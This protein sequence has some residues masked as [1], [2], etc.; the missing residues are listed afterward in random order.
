MNVKRI[1]GWTFV[2]IGLLL[3]VLIA[4]AALLLHSQRFH[5]YVLAKIEQTA[6]ES[7]GGKVTIQSF[8][9]HW[10]NLSADIY[11]L[12]IH[13]REKPG[14]Q[15]LLA[16][17]RLFVDVRIISLLHKQ[18]DL[19]EIVVDH[20]VVRYISYPDGTSN[21]P[22]STAP[23]KKSNTNVFDLGIKH[24]LLDRGEIYYQERK[25]DLDADL[26]NLLLEVKLN[27]PRNRYDGKLS[28]DHG[29]LR[30]R[31]ARP[32]PH[33]LR[34]SFTA[35]RNHADLQS[36]EMDLGTSRLW[37]NAYLENYSTPHLT[38][39]YRL[40]MYPQD[41]R[42][43]LKNP[44]L[45]AGEITLAGNIAYN[46]ADSR[47]FMRALAAQGQLSSPQ[48]LVNTP[49]ARTQI[50]AVEGRFQLNNGKLTTALNA[51]LLS[52]TF[53]ATLD[54]ANLDATPASFLK[55]SLHGISLAEA[56]AALR[57][58]G[59]RNFPVTGKLDA[60]TEAQ[61]TGPI[62]T[63][64][65]H[66]DATLKAAVSQQRG[67]GDN[68][69]PVNGAVHANYDGPSNVL[70]LFNTILRT[71]Q[72]SITFNGQVS[73]HSDLKI[74]ART[75]DVR[76]LKA[77][78]SSLPS[79]S[80]SAPAQQNNFVISGPMTLDASVRG[81][82]K[83]PNVSGNINAHDLVVQG[84]QWKSVQAAFQASPSG[85]VVPQGSLVAA[86]K[87][88]AKFSFKVG[89]RDWKYSPSQP[90]A[91]SINVQQ[92]PLRDLQHIGGVNYPVNGILSVDAKV[93]G[94]QLNPVGNG[95]VMVSNGRVQDQPL[96]VSVH[97]AAANQTINSDLQVRTPA[98]NLQGTASYR[99]QARAYQVHLRAPGVVLS[100]LEVLQ[101]RNVPLNGTLMF[102]ADGAGTLDDPQL[103]A[104]MQIP[105]LQVKNA[106]V[107]SVRGDL[108]VANHRAQFDIN[109]D[110]ANS[111]VAA[112]GTVDLRGDYPAN[113][114]FDTRAI[115]IE[116]LVALY[117]P[118][119]N[120]DFH[121]QI[122]LHATAR[123]PLKNKNRMEAH[124]IIPTLKAT[125][126]DIQIGNTQPIRADYENAVL[127][128]EPSQIQGTDTSL[129]FQGTVPL[130]ASNQPATLTLQGNVDLRIVKLFQP[131]VQSGGTVVLDLR[132]NRA[133]GNVGVGGQV[134]FNKVRF[135]T[136]SSPM[137]VQNLNGVLDVKN[138]Q[139]QI[140]NLQGE[141][142]GGT[143][144]AGGTITYRPQLAVNVSLQAQHVRLR[145]PNGT[146]SVIDSNLALSGDSQRGT[147]DGRVLLDSLG[148]TNDFDLA[149]FMGQFSG[150]SASAPPSSPFLQNL[151][152]NVALQSTSQL[153]LVSSQVSLEGQVNLHISGT[154]AQPVILGRAMLN[155]G[156]IFFM[157]NRY[158]LERGILNFINP[159][160]TNPD[161][162][163]LIT[164]TIE[165]YNLSVTLLGPVDRLR[166]TYVSDPP[167]PPV[168]IINLIARGQTT[169]EG[170]PASFDAN[171]AIASGLAGQVSSRIGKLA[172]ISSLQIDPL[173]GGNNTNPGA[174]IALQQ[175]VTRNFIFTFSTDV[176]NTQDDIVQGEYQVTPKWS[177]SALR[178]QYGGYGFDAKFHTSF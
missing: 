118:L 87:A 15:P 160:E 161:V 35:D 91:A 134:R 24:V 98:G 138:N 40:V 141:S 175:R 99:P 113:L 11:G 58:S 80:S 29:E 5:E 13:G 170:T 68:I 162:N 53:L 107:Q 56:R 159:V 128:L 132:A 78:A 133:G 71:P 31:T 97:F 142:G 169:E 139:V 7:T 30:M 95:T 81:D 127:R 21:I 76:E 167:L 73:K 124:L 130:Q 146:R 177:V 60:Y 151:K 59:A 163:I 28:Y 65:A 27:S 37:L 79:T 101:A 86:G 123:G 77:L 6:S 3:I 94:T 119:P 96:D 1:V 103:H 8:N 178:D 174:R 173:L 114:S 43:V 164:T 137:G 145:Y 84:D 111:Y 166:T 104:S 72:S 108:T 41:F 62:T 74:V 20:P 39:N 25:Q 70:R 50:R 126:Q 75:T 19:N 122:E 83:R 150:N 90:L 61:W 26:H 57:S 171:S 49:Q 105:R 117:K 112:R 44:D 82:M 143:V 120:Q 176:T 102:T 88:Q 136:L 148:F 106:S 9:F 51:A 36:A 63:L 147:L 100:K 69:V 38:G 158:R 153:Q 152:L 47:P 149:T 89:L 34:A 22:Q 12:V 18:V 116:S 135:A 55:A 14:T 46:A 125:Y 172:G 85:I 66:T 67:A 168:D 109:S 129:R 155:N 2:G 23:K 64:R 10:S 16:V 48:L 121:G 115:P 154:A 144:S 140:T 93:R 92:M 131:D 165:Q 42:D 110:L 52:G 17:D 54:V 45:P 33:S 156:D 32:L 4:A 157:N